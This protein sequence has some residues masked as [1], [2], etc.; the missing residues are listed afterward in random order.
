MKLPTTRPNGSATRARISASSTGPNGTA[1]CGSLVDV[2]DVLL[3]ARHAGDPRDE[4]RLVGHLEVVA[5]RDVLREDLTGEGVLVAHRRG[6]RGVEGHVREA[7]E[8]GVVADRDVLGRPAAG[9]RIDADE[10]D[11]LDRARG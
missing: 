11:V 6:A 3:E 8:V 5:D 7:V 4:N 10:V 9:R 1:R 2:G